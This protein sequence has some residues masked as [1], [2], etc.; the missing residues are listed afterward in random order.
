MRYAVHLARRAH[1]EYCAARSTAKGKE[2]SGSPS[3][4]PLVALS[5]GPY[6][7]MLGNGAEC[8]YQLVWRRLS[9]FII[10]GA[11]MMLSQRA[12]S[13]IQATTAPRPVILNQPP[14]TSQPGTWPVYAS[15]LKT[16]QSGA[17]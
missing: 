12:I 16:S 2:S 3:A 4:T 9:C 11:L 13:Q 1:A 8:K 17:Q 14:P 6:G 7:A 10:L 15:L 5:L